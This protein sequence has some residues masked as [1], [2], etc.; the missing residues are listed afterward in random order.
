[1]LEWCSSS[2]SFLVDGVTM[3]MLD[4]MVNIPNILDIMVS[5]LFVD[6]VV[7]EIIYFMVPFGNFL[8][9]FQLLYLI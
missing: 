1:M 2:S 7:V 9:T 4:V 6:G 3:D 8:V 5:M